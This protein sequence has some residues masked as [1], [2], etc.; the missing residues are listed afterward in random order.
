MNL[1]LKQLLQILRK[2]E[3]T[4][5]KVDSK[6]TDAEFIAWM[7][8]NIDKD[9]WPKEV[10]AEFQK[11]RRDPDFREFQVVYKQM[12]EVLPTFQFGE[13]DEQTRKNYLQMFVKETG[14]IPF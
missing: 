1:Y 9:Q 4:L 3:F 11:A 2:Y 8:V 12:R 10:D 6:Y 5:N 7:S 14:G 13:L